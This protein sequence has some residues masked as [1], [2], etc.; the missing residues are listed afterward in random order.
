MAASLVLWIYTLLLVAGGLVGF[1]KAGSKASLTMS[2][3]FAVPL[4][5]CAARVIAYPYVA[6]ILI[7]GLLL[8]FLARYSRSRKFMPSGMMAI[9]SAAALIAHLL[10]AYNILR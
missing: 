6:D 1:L 3:L 10:L 5:L 9:V 4:G 7:N 8:F 2:L